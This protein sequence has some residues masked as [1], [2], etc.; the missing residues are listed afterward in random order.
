M[1]EMN[2]PEFFYSIWTNVTMYMLLS[3]LNITTWGIIH[4]YIMDRSVSAN[5]IKDYMI[6]ILIMFTF[7]AIAYT[8]CLYA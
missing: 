6:G 5:T 2:F 7:L 8:I 3:G 4:P 1:P